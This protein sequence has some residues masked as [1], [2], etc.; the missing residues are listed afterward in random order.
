LR[1]TQIKRYKRAADYEVQPV[2]RRSISRVIR[3]ENRYRAAGS[4]CF[5]FQMQQN[6]LK[7]NFYAFPRKPSEFPEFAWW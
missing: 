5:L 6:D 7:V 2:A 3:L 4:Y 1:A